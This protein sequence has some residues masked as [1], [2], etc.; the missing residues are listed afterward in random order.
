MLRREAQTLER[1]V[2]VGAL[3]GVP[4]GEGIALFVLHYLLWTRFVD[5]L[6]L[7]LFIVLLYGLVAAAVGLVLAHL[8]NRLKYQI[9]IRPD[10]ETA[11]L[12]ALWVFV[13]LNLVGHVF[14]RFGVLGIP[15]SRYPF[16]QT[17]YGMLLWSVVKALGVGLAAAGV[18]WLLYGLVKR[19]QV[20][21][22]SPSGQALRSA[23]KA[24]FAAQMNQPSPSG[25]LRSA[26]QRR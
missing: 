6:L 10:N 21:P 15:Y 24:G 3:L 5:C 11:L 18:S 13:L 4:V 25:A 20:A 9:L 26:Q 23:N 16:V 7:N 14:S 2:V 19:A 12:V 22:G 17:F 8:V 1:G